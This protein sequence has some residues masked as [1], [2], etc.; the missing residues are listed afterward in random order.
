[1]L[2]CPFCANILLVES[3]K[4]LRFFCQTCPYIHQVQHT[5]RKVVPLKRK[6]LGAVLGSEEAWK[7]AETTDEPCPACGHG[8][9]YFRA[10]ASPPPP[11]RLLLARPSALTPKSLAPRATRAHTHHPRLRQR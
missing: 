10:C 1:M 4:G 5:Y 3:A 2:F 9:A 8:K 7:S 11:S 6:A